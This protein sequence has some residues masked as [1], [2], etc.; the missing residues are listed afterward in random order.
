MQEYRTKEIY[1]DFYKNDG[2]PLVVV[3]G[4]SRPG[5]PASLSENLLNYLKQNYNVLLLAYFGVGE[6][7]KTLENIPVE[8]FVNSIRFIQENHKTCDNQVVIIGQSKGGE[9]AL[10]LSNY[11]ESSLTIACVPG[12]Y[13][14][15]GLPVTPFSIKHPKSSWAFNNKGLPY[16]KFY[17]DEDI[18]RDAEN[19][20]YCSCHEKSI[21]KNFNK[22][23]VINVDNY[24]GKI[25]LLS[26]ENDKYWPS[27]NMSN[28]L[29]ENSKNKNNIDHIT[30]DLEG[31]YFLNYNQSVDEIINFLE[32]NVKFI[33]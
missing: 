29:I 32:E 25:L 19:N 31:H 12:C 4:G 15:Q 10:L 30:L 3:L 2:K 33:S 23:A 17:Y 27:K 1:G 22:E 11:V 16:I 24:K 13:V 21:E 14:F 7:P 9:A 6:L 26:S 28:I 8:Y 20:I 5:L 18:M